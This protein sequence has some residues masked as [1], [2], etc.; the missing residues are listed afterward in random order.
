MALA[1]PRSAAWT[2]I[3]SSFPSNGCSIHGS[4]ASPSSSA[5]FRAARRRHVGELRGA[6]ARRASG[7]VPQTKR[8]SSRRTPSTCPTRH[9]VYGEYARACARIA[10]GYTPVSQVASIDEMFLD[11][12][13]CEEPLLR[14]RRRRPRSHDRAHRAQ[15]HERNREAARPAVERGDRDEPLDGEGRERRCQAAR[16]AARRPR[17]GSWPSRRR[18]GAA[19]SRASAPSRSKAARRS[20]R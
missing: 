13:G 2:W 12:S 11:F 3:R 10:E 14:R 7:D 8:S 5:D 6:R 9:G 20:A 1:A 15:A 18:S 4:W 16:R 19:S 17:A